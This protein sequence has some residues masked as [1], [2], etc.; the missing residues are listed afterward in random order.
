MQS[1]IC[2]LLK[3]SLGKFLVGIAGAV[4]FSAF[5]WHFAPPGYTAKV[6]YGLALLTGAYK[7]YELKA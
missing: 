5:Y 2:G 4:L 6:L 1:F 7:L 3:T